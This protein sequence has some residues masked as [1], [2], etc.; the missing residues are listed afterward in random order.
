MPNTFF[1]LLERLRFLTPTAKACNVSQ[2]SER[3]CSSADRVLASGAK[4]LEFESPQA[5][6]SFF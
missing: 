3:A 6:H 5:R 2:S 1:L 4:G